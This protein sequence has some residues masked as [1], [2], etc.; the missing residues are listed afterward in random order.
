MD[1][2]PG[3]ELDALIAATISAG[4]WKIVDLKAGPRLYHTPFALPLCSL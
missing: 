2:E 1:H 3:R 4:P